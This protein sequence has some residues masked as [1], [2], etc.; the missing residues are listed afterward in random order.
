MV[1]VKVLKKEKSK[2]KK[3]DYLVFFEFRGQERF[4]IINFNVL[5]YNKV[6]N[7]DIGDEI[8][9]IKSFGRTEKPIFLIKGVRKNGV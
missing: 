5:R 2:Y 3:N 8:F 7:I 1:W 9:V 6:D 4:S